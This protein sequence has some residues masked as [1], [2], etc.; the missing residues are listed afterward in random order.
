MTTVAVQLWLPL[1]HVRVRH[2]LTRPG[3]ACPGMLPQHGGLLLRG[4]PEVTT[5]IDGDKRVHSRF[6]ERRII[7]G[8]YQVEGLRRATICPSIPATVASTNKCEE[9]P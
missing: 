8:S 5:R 3:S 1:C 4:H 2:H 7:A 9:C 6:Q